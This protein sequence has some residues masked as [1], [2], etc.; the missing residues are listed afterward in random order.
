MAS[1]SPATLVTFEQAKAQLRINHDE[2]DNEIY[3]KLADAEFI[4]L[5]AM[6]DR[7]DEDWT[8]A[9]VPPAVRAAILKQLA[10]LWKHR[11][12]GEEKIHD[13]GLAPG[14]RYLLQATGYRD[15]TLG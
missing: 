15:L 11:G 13:S 4:V 5:S 10:Y 14:V 6:G 3:E 2:S 8:D 1:P 7:Y 9:T 12:D